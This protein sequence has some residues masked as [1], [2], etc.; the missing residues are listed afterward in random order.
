MMVCLLALT[1]AA[2]AAPWRA[3]EVYQ[4]EV[5]RHFVVNGLEHELR[6]NHDST[7]AWFR[8]QWLCLWNANQ[9]PAEGKPGQLNYV[10]TSPD[11]RTWSEPQ[12]AFSSDQ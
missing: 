11:G 5:E 9:V 6:Y 1:T 12:P 3:Y 10:S 2:C 8:D 4:P 7:I